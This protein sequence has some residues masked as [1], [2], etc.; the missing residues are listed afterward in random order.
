MFLVQVGLISLIL[1]SDLGKVLVQGVDLLLQQGDLFFV[2]VIQS[3]V[4]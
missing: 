4:I 2:S 3:L 1:G